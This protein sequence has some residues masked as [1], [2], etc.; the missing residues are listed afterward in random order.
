MIRTLSKLV[1]DA[2][3]TAFH[4]ML[5]TL[6]NE[7]RLM[8][9]YTQNV[10]GIDTSLPPLSTSVPLSMK[11]PWPRTI[12]LHGGLEKMVCSKCNRVSDFQASLFEGPLPPLCV[13]CLETDKIRI[14]HAGKRSHGIGRL[15]P[16]IVLY[17]EHNP[18]EEAIGTV[19]SADLRTRPDAVFVVGTS[20]KIPGVRRIV[21]EMCGVVRSRRNGLAIW[22]N[23]EPPPVGK[24]FEDCFDLIV[25]GACDDVAYHAEMKRWDEDNVGTNSHS[26]GDLSKANR[27]K[28][29][30]EGFVVIQSPTKTS[31]DHSMIAPAPSQPKSSNPL[32]INMEARVPPSREFDTKKSPAK[33]TIIPVSMSGQ[34]GKSSKAIHRAT[35]VVLANSNRFS[36]AASPTSNDY[37]FVVTIRPHETTVSLILRDICEPDGSRTK[38]T[39]L[40]ALYTAVNKKLTNLDVTPTSYSLSDLS[41]HITDDDQLQQVFAFERQYTRLFR[42]FLDPIPGA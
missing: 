8:R 3:P 27:S 38:L 26:E 5:A 12:Q 7:G 20:M 28:T 42:L 9:L 41:R 2:R 11:G 34:R 35:T 21:R 29:G 14:N 15:R 22:V 33:K 13:A 36:H 6:A 17:H 37:G 18:D 32:S 4:K 31:S 39:S 25:K 24:E 23:H 30:T 16:R 40:K 1:S 19:V 10:D